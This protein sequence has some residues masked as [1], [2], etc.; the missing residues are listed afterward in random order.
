M[1]SRRELVTGG[2]AAAAAARATDSG[3]A[4]VQCT[5]NS[6]LLNEI[7]TD[8]Q[9]MAAPQPVP[10]AFAIGMVRQSQRTFL[11]QAGK[12]PDQIDVGLDTWDAVIDWHVAALQPFQVA[13]HA[14]GRYAIR[15]LTTN[16]V[17]KP[18]LPEN[19]VSQGQ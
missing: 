8:V 1:F 11:K 13:R 17:L 19:Y 15:F 6:G 4:P 10:G 18:E 7:L 9:K 16:I 2:L 14:D 12:Y 3:A 5:D